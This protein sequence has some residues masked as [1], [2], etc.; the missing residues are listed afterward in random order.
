MINVLAKQRKL[1][2]GAAAKFIYIEA[3]ALGVLVSAS[4]PWFD[5]ALQA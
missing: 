2:R 1:A 3:P 4:W 5:P